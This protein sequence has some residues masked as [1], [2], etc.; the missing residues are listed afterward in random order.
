MNRRIV[1]AASLM[2]TREIGAEVAARLPLAV[3]L[4]QEL[5]SALRSIKPLLVMVSLEGCAY[6]MTVR[7]QHLLPLFRQGTQPVVQVDMRSDTPLTDFAGRSRTHDEVVRSWSVVAAPT[8]LFFGR[9]GREIAPRLEGVSIPDF[10][11]A[12]LEERTRVARLAL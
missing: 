6:C 8:V 11:G 2:L 9:G 1:L 12:Y 10:Y 7:E 4:Q 5:N 3:S